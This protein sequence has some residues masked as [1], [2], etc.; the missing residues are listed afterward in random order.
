MTI[1]P[2]A[3]LITNPHSDALPPDPNYQKAVGAAKDFEALLL[4]QMLHSMRE[5]GANWLGSGED[6]ESDTAI[7]MG[8][9][10]LGKALAAGGGLGLAKAV[11]KSL[12]AT[13]P[14]VPNVPAKSPT[15]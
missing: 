2:Y 1:R 12:A 5:G 10:Q 4:S 8:E 9:E 14:P 6:S 13:L 11:S 7:G 3:G 15:E